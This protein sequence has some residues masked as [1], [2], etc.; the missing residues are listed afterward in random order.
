MHFFSSRETYTRIQVLRQWMG[1]TVANHLTHASK[2]NLLYIGDYYLP[3]YYYLLGTT[4]L[5][6]YW[7]KLRPHTNMS[8]TFFCES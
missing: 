6:Y 2:R 8:E 3:F 1:S 4:F 5:I 7:I